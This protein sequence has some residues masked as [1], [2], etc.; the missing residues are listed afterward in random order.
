[1]AIREATLED[2]DP[3][4]DIFSTVI[5]TGDTYVFHPNTPRKDLGIYWFAGGMKTFVLEEN[6]KILGTYVLKANH[7]DL[8]SHIANA[9]YMVH[10]KAQGIGIGKKLGDHSLKT[11]KEMGF[12]AIQFNMIVSTNRVAIVLWEKLG[13]EIIG[14]I[15]GGF[16]HWTLGYVDTYIMF[17]KL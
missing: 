10:P 12:A 8:G 9:S 5:K 17:R 3:I 15:P 14:T 4:W 11:A 13:F 2:Y 6:G 1:M 7:I 16:K